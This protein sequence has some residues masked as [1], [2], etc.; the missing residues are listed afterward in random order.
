MITGRIS[1]YE[2]TEKLAEGGRGVL[3]VVGHRAVQVSVEGPKCPT[4]GTSR[5][6]N[7][8][9]VS[10]PDSRQRRIGNGLVCVGSHL[11]W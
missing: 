4:P 6:G 2:I 11:E 8:Q 3:C 7:F 10:E 5:S 9:A 1:H